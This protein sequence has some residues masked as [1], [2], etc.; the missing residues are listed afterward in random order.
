[1]LASYFT[2][3]YGLPLWLVISLA[4]RTIASEPRIFGR[5]HVVEFR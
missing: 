4:V 2:V 1:M 5:S 3:E